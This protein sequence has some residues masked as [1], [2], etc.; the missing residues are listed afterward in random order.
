MIID[1]VGKT[2]DKNLISH[3]CVL[4]CYYYDLA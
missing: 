4:H 1:G 2:L 3:D